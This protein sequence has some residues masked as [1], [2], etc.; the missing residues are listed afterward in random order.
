MSSLPP[1]E[2]SPR[3]AFP[4]VRAA[5]EVAA[6]LI[7]TAWL[8][9]NAGL[10]AL[11]AGCLRAIA[12]G[13]W[14]TAALLGRDGGTVV[15]ALGALARV[16]VLFGLPARAI[17]RSPRRRLAWIPLLIVTGVGA[18][19][20]SIPALSGLVTWGL[21]CACAALGFVASSKRAWRIFA[22]APWLV[23]MEPLLGH[24]PLSDNVWTPKRLED[25]CWSSNDGVHPLDLR[26]DFM[27]SRYFGVTMARP[28]LFLVTG[29]R[30]SFWAR[31]D[32]QNRVTLGPPL[33]LKG[34]F[35]QG[36]MRDGA[37]WVTKRE[38]VCKIP[39]PSSEHEAPAPSCTKVSG[40]R[41]IGVEL[42]Y[43]D[44]LCPDDRPTVYVSQLLRGGFL[45][46][47]PASEQ[48]RFHHVMPGGFNLQLVAR[49]DGAVLGIT[50]ARFFVFD[51][52][53]DRVLED[54]P[55][56]AVA[57]G[58]DV[59]PHDDAV[60]ISDFA[61]RVRL[62]SRGPEGRYTFTRA[63]FV[64]APRRVA[65]SPRCDRILVTSGSDRDALVL[66]RSTLTVTRRFRLG[67][68]LRD[69]VFLDDRWAAA[70]DACAVTLVDTGE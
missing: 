32:A 40:P 23:A 2:P 35:W 59:C 38:H 17:A 5:I 22:L 31:R 43:V 26:P 8:L 68:G 29:E 53:I 25:R 1:P 50:T 37:A 11:L 13:A 19:G 46:F 63:A 54:H 10:R 36:C 3:L 18:L 67:P 14:S 45:E 30:R 7:I 28:D 64:S 52:K 58:I 70:A 27:V 47:D 51:P 55:A 34:N 6:A 20:L 69:V 12:D 39:L 44:I 61:G 56:G 60:V 48:T 65:F 49:S 33:A 15:V 42:D 16:L 21:F 9:S 4:D 57:M 41:A 24:S 66:R 62:F